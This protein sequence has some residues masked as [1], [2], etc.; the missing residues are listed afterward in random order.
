MSE[1][2]RIDSEVMGL[3]GASHVFQQPFNEALVHQVTTAFLAGGRAGTKAQKTRSQVSGGGVKPWRQKGTGRARTGTIRNP[4][5]RGG[6]RIF[7]AVP[8]DHSQKVNRKMYRVALRSIFSELSKQGC[9]LLVENFD[10]D[11]PKT[12]NLLA[13]L[14][15]M[16]LSSVLIVDGK[17]S[18]NLMLAARNIPNVDAVNVHHLNPVSMLSFDKLLITKA[19]V[20]EIIGWLS[21]A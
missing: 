13:Q 18:E 3:E 15:A 17:P 1:I 12:K 5:W 10:V 2:K 6:G 21:D 16:D 11:T 4:I 8:R 9:L 14:K 7:A 19:A 20:T